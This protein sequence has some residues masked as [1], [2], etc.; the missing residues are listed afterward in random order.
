MTENL[1]GTNNVRAKLS[2]MMFLQF[3]VWGAWYVT[4]GQYMAKIGLGDSIA[5]VYT[6]GPIAAILSPM[7][8]GTIADRYFNSEKVL[9]VLMFIAGGTFLL[10][11]RVAESCAENWEAT[12]AAWAAAG[13]DQKEQLGDGFLFF[14]P[15]ISDHLPFIGLI[16]LHMLCYMPTLGL[17]NTIAFT[18][19]SSQEKDFPVIRVFGTIGWIAAGVVVSYA[20]KADETALP[21]QVAGG[22]AIAL[23][24]YSL[25]L[26]HT[27]P[28][29]KGEKA[30]IGKMLGLDA[31]VMLKNPGFFVFIL[32]SFLICIPLAGYYAYA[33]NFVNAAGFTSPAGVMTAGQVSEIFFMLLIPFFFR[34]LGVKWML[35][36]G[37]A[38]WALRYA[39]F[40]M[41]APEG[42]KWMIFGGIVLHG[43]CYDFL[44]VTGFIYTDK[45]APGSIRAQAQSLLVL[46]TQGLGLGVGAQVMGAVVNG[47]G[48]VDKGELGAQAAALRGQAADVAGS[49]AD[50][51]LGQASELLLK[52]D[53]WSGTWTIPAV[54]SGLILVVFLLLF[55]DRS[56]DGDDQDDTN[57]AE[58]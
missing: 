24:L 46:V 17:T 9:S 6:V 11:P 19:I 37:M 40:A 32:C 43:V 10:I 20:L 7:F 13:L 44:F 26:P 14:Q 35:G 21:F 52:A 56:A 48:A 51:L 22:A 58:G 15:L 33:Q 39:L 41:A 31:L 53:N 38:C 25:A 5:W 55:W 45:K 3:F 50:A 42:V 30:T 4:A 2:S 8:L 16:F 34:R 28:P 23:G 49:D 12:Q 1:S 29:M 27:P 18:N 54:L 47:N 36:I 57:T